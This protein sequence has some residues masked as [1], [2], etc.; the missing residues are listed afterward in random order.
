MNL[1]LIMPMNNK[2]TPQIQTSVKNKSAFLIEPKASTLDFLR[3]FARVYSNETSK[4]SSKAECSL[5]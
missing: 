2:S 4:F 3:I 1:F 5:N